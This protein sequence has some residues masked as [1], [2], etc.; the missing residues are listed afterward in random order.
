MKVIDSYNALVGGIV[1]VL[2]YIFG[3]HWMLFA[4]FLAFNV[5]DWLTGW[6]TSRMAPR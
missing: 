5:A 6:M 3:E 2:T 4:L 1:A